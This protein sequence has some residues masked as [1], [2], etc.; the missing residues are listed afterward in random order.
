[1]NYTGFTTIKKLCTNIIIE[2]PYISHVLN[3]A[4]FHMNVRF[5]GI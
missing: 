5:V 2:K 4:V 3:F 1:M